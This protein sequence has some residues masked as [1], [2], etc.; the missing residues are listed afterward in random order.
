MVALRT[1]VMH[2]LAGVLL[3]ADGRVLLAQR[4][5]G[6]QLAG[7]WE[8]PGGKREAGETPR[9][10]LAR[11]LREELDIGVQ[12]AEP[13]VA[14]PWRHERFD[15]LLDAWRVLAWDGAPRPAEGQALQWIAPAQ[16]E[17]A[18]LAGADQLIWQALLRA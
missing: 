5:P 7:M 6:K 14:I 18:T 2:V 1:G 4:P 17:V 15:L 13:F 10:A 12:R 8:F 9:Q 16:V 3:D 11:E